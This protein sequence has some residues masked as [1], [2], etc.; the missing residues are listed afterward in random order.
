MKKMLWVMAFLLGGVV[1][2]LLM[3]VVWRARLSLPLA[4][5]IG[6]KLEQIPDQ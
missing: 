3:P 2:G 6:E 4:A 1:G 5:A